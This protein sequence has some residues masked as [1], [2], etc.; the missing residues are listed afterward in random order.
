MAEAC[1]NPLTCDEDTD[2]SSET[3][4]ETEAEDGAEDGAEAP[5]DDSQSDD[6]QSE[7]SDDAE[8]GEDDE[9][10]LDGIVFSGPEDAIE[11]LEEAGA[12]LAGTAFGDLAERTTEVGQPVELDVGGLE[13]S[14]NV[15]AAAIVFMA[16][17][18]GLVAA[19][20]RRGRNLYGLSVTVSRYLLISAVGV[21]AALIAT[22]VSNEIAS[23]AVVANLPGE[24][25]TTESHLYSGALASLMVPA[26]TVAFDFQPFMVAILIATWPMTAALGLMPAY[27]SAP[28]VVGG[29]IAANLLWPPFAALCV[30]R[31]FG[32]FPDVTA[33][34][35]W[36]V[37]ALVVAA[38]F[39]VVALAATG[40]NPRL[41][42]GAP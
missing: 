8:S 36:T 5:S 13:A 27:R 23:A 4:D 7:E 29:L 2:E 16:V 18:T 15:V 11:A 35:W 28:N 24:V 42:R 33:A 1:S 22:E 17:A 31:A 32:E 20:I 41:E 30:G 25:D 34:T 40:T 14:L 38:V 3:G 19:I 6:S 12:E 9:N 37:I 26:L 39:N 10:D 21:A